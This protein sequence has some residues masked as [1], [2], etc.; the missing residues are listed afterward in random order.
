LTSPQG[1]HRIVALLTPGAIVGDLSM[2]DG[3]PRSASVLA[4]SNTIYGFN[5]NADRDAF[6]IESAQ[7]RVVFC[8]W[9]GGG[10]G[11]ARSLGIF[12]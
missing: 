1:E 6:H 9:D 12:P 2:I 5:S 11:Y 8:I 10:N 4:V 7:D 3:L